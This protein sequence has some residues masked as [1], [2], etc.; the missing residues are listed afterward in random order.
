M[1]VLGD[2]CPIWEEEKKQMKYQNFQC[3]SIKGINQTLQN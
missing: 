1:Q 3:T 2:F